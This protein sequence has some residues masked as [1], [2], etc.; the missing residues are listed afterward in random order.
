MKKYLLAVFVSGIW[1]N[2]SEFIRNELVIKELWIN[3]FHEIGLAFPSAPLNG[4]VWGLWAFIFASILAW[5][6]TRFN[7]LSSSLIAWIIGF[8]LLWVAMWNMGVLPSKIIYWTVPWSFAEVFVAAFICARIM[9]INRLTSHN[10]T[11][12]PRRLFY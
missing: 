8:V 10:R 4:A 2:I 11:A 7:T 9:K 6:C 1:I 5:L 12:Q 3:G